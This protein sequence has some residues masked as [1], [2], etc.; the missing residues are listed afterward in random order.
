MT[1][2]HVISFCFWI[3]GRCRYIPK[4][5]FS[6]SLW[7]ENLQLLWGKRNTSSQAK[8]SELELRPPPVNPTEPACYSCSVA[9]LYPTLCDP[10]DCSTPSFPL[11]PSPRVCLN[12]WCHPTISSSVTPFSCL[13]VLPPSGSFAVSWLFASG[14]QSIGALASVPVNIQGWFPLGFTGL[15]SLLSK[16]LSQDLEGW[17][18]SHAAQGLGREQ[19]PSSP[20]WQPWY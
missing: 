12:Q 16:E 7:K 5:Y 19:F 10:M 13:Q 9:Q 2:I 1:R 17:E 15:I 20:T 8:P 3:L 18:K 6:S 4:F 11:S 14:V